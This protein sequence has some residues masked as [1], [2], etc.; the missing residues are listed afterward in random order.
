MIATVLLLQ[1][2]TVFASQI[3]PREI[4]N[5]L[6][7]TS[8]DG[9]IY[10]FDMSRQLSS[11]WPVDL[12]G[13]PV[14]NVIAC[15]L[16]DDINTQEF[17]L[18]VKKTDKYYLY[19]LSHDGKIIGNAGMELGFVPHSDP[20]IFK[21]GS[22]NVLFAGTKDG[23]VRAAAL[24]DMSTPEGWPI[25]IDKD[26]PISIAAADINND[27]MEEILASSGDK[28]WSISYKAS[29]EVS[30]IT[31]ADTKTAYSKLFKRSARTI[32]T[33]YGTDILKKDTANN[34][35]T[36]SGPF[37]HFSQ[38]EDAEFYLPPIYFSPNG[39]KDKADISIGLTFDKPTNYKYTLCDEN[40][41]TVADL[42]DGNGI[43]NGIEVF[44]W[45]G[46][47]K[48][49]PTYEVYDAVLTAESSLSDHINAKRKVILDT[50]PPSFESFTA[51]NTIFGANSSGNSGQQK[52][53]FKLSKKADLHIK[54]LDSNKNIYKEDILKNISAFPSQCILDGKRN[55]G[56]ASEESYGYL[57]CAEDF[58]GNLSA[59]LEGTVFLDPTPYIINVEPSPESV[60]TIVENP[61]PIVFKLQVCTPC[62]IEAQI[63][64]SSGPVKTIIPLSKYSSGEYKVSWEG[65]DDNGNKL[66]EGSYNYVFTAKYYSLSSEKNGTVRIDNSKPYASQISITPSEESV[67]ALD[68]M[69]DNIIFSYYLSEK[70][71]VTVDIL[72][73]S[74]DVV[75]SI[76]SSQP[77]EAK[78]NS[79]SF[80]KDKLMSGGVFEPGEYSIRLKLVDEAGNEETINKAKLTIISELSIS[81]AVALP[82]TFTPNG[83]NHDDY[84]TFRYKVSGGVGDV[85]A[86]VKI[87][88]LAGATMKTFTS[89][90]SSASFDLEIWDGKDENNNLCPDGQYQYEISASDNT[91]NQAS[92]VT[93]SLTLISD[94]TIV[95]YADPK[96]I[97]S[98]GNDMTIFYNINYQGQLITGNSQVSATIYDPSN[99]VVYNFSDTKGE[100]SYSQK[101]AGQNNQTGGVVPNGTY[102]LEAKS[103]DPTGTI[104]VY[105]TDIVVGAALQITGESASPAIFTPNGDD[106]DDTTTI[107][108]FV[109]C[110][111]GNGIST[112][113]IKSL[114]GTTV[115]VFS[116]PYSPGSNPSFTWDGKDG[117]N[118][119]CPDGKYTYVITAADPGSDLSPSVAGSIILA[120]NA[121][122]TIDADPKTLSP[123]SDGVDDSSTVH[124]AI[125]Y[126]GLFSGN[127]QISIGVLNQSGLKVYSLTDTKGEGSYS[128]VWGGENNQIGG[129]VPDG[130]YT[131]E[132][133]ATDPTGTVYSY[134]ADLIVNA[135]LQ[136]TGES[137]TPLIFTPNGD[138]HDD[139]TTLSYFVSGGVGSITSTVEIKSIAGTIVR[140]FTIP[141]ALSSTPYAPSFTWDGKDGSGSMCL[142]GEYTYKITVSDSAGNIYSSTPESIVLAANTAI[143]MY[144]TP[145]TLSPNG[146]GVTNASTMFCVISYGGLISG[147]SQVE[148][149]IFNPSGGK[150][151]SLT[152][153]KGEG[154]YSYVW[155]G[156]NNQTGG[157]VP[158]GTYTLK[159]QASDPTGANY[160]YTTD[161]SI[162]AE[163]KVTGESAVPVII[164]PNG[165][166]HNDNTTI[167]YFVSG[168]VGNGVS[169]V[170]IKSLASTTV[171]V[172]SSPYSPGS[173]PS[174]TWD[175]KDSSNNMCPDGKYIC[176]ISA[177]DSAGNTSSLTGGNITLVQS[178]TISLEAAPLKISPN[179]DGVDEYT[180]I[181]YAIDYKGGLI[182]GSSQIAVNI[183]DKSGTKVYSF[184]DSKGEGNYSLNWD[185][186]N[187]QTGGVV[188]DGTY[189]LEVQATDPTGTVY[190]FVADIIIDRGPPKI[191]DNGLSSAAPITP[192]GDSQQDD[193]TIKYQV[194]RVGNPIASIEV[195]IY[196]SAI[197]FDA[198]TLVR[199]ING[200]AGG[201]TLWDGRVD[202]PGGNG[203]KDGNGYADKGLYKYVIK[204]TD[205][206]GNTATLASNNTIEVDKVYL[207]FYP[208]ISI[209]NNPYFSPNGDGVKD[210][211][212]ITFQLMTTQ[213]SN[214]FY[215]KA[216]GMK[217]LSSYN[218]GKVTMKVK[219]MSGNTVKT[220]MNAVPCV[221]DL[222]Y[223]VTWDGTNAS[224]TIV[225]DGTY[226]FE[227]T[228]V[229]MIGDPAANNMIS[230]ITPN[231][232]DVV[233]DTVS[234]TV[235][236]KSP[237]N[238][239]WQKGNLDIFGTMTDQSPL[240]YSLGYGASVTNLC[241]GEGNISNGR[242]VS[243]DTTTVAGKTYQVNLYAVDRAGNT[244]EAQILC[245]IDND[246]PIVSTI[247]IESN[248]LPSNHYNPYTDGTV[249]VEFQ[250]DDNSF[251]TGKYTSPSTSVYMTTEVCYGTLQIKPLRTNNAVPSGLYSTGWNGINSSGD[252]VNDGNYQI[253]LTLTD[254]AGNQTVIT[255]QITLE[256]DQRMTSRESNTYSRYPNLMFNGSVLNLSYM[257]GESWGIGKFKNRTFNLSSGL[258][259]CRSEFNYCEW[260]RGEFEIAKQQNVTAESWIYSDSNTI[261]YHN[262]YDTSNVDHLNY[263][264]S[265]N[266]VNAGSY[267]VKNT[268]TSLSPGRYYVHARQYVADD[269]LG[270]HNIEI[271]YSEP[272]I[273]K[274]KTC[275]NTNNL[276][277]WN[278]SSLYESKTVESFASNS[279]GFITHYA[280]SSLFYFPQWNRTIFP[281]SNKEIIYSKKEGGIW[282]YRRT[283]SGAYDA[284]YSP[285]EIRISSAE[286]DS[287]NP[288]IAT[289][290]SGNKV[291]IAWEDWRHLKG[292]IYLRTSTTSGETWSAETQLI[293]SSENCTSP[294]LSFNGK[295]VYVAF[296]KDHG[297]HKELNIVRSEDG[298][299]SWTTPVRITCNHEKNG[300][301]FNPSIV[302]M[303]DGSAYIAWED[304]RTGTSEIY[305]QKIPYNFAPIRSAGFTALSMAAP[306]VM[307]GKPSF[308]IMSGNVTPE[309]ISP[310]DNAAVKTLRP[311]FKWYGVQNVTDYRIECATS[312]D[313]SSLANS[314]DYFTATISD[315]SGVKPVCEFTQNEHFMGLDEN[316]PS[317][318]FWYWRV[319]TIT[320]EASTSEVGSFRIELPASLSGVTNWPNP[321][322]PNK[323]RTKIRYRLG[324][325]PNSVTIRIYDITGALVKELDGTTNP[326]GASIWNKYNDVEWDGR[327]GRGDMVLNG[328]YPFEISVNY[329]DKSVTGRGKAVVL[330]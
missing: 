301:A 312:S 176:E 236:I 181:S 145:K 252:Y 23:Y 131:L 325:E 156:Q 134:T 310:I 228:A 278:T 273:N 98:S 15:E 4:N 64:G 178:P 6:F 122:I 127:S 172:F 141:Y 225:P 177:F 175:G 192:N 302:A 190:P 315:V 257:T 233:V 329:G 137:A 32:K 30:E 219:D 306:V 284:E 323:E 163:L 215:T 11:G 171:K 93:G 108:Y 240:N 27:N 25:L 316:T 36:E 224:G 237:A 143:S 39:N 5:Q 21:T 324:R 200:S 153:T 196:D 147:D 198:S 111:V 239:S 81:N 297:G 139:N 193:V 167:S 91:G 31:N 308:T 199:H 186:L 59:T 303:P 113:E 69:T 209:P 319:Q 281:N 280:W 33:Y 173:N 43:P 34:L 121:S 205:V 102:R 157:F 37:H 128:Y 109:S 160:S 123:N 100:G 78:G 182:S 289:D 295:Y 214:P 75:S 221:K 82:L 8:I 164:T 155:G 54:Y 170:E 259:S 271:S 197:T 231:F 88:S 99:T 70:C 107:S 212:T 97:S 234:P 318:P 253:I 291:F 57:I 206:V 142:D 136:I 283:N 118:N 286:G 322:D 256:D 194:T 162:S 311:T 130:T 18:F 187:N 290:T 208:P 261:T 138:N 62:D 77:Q 63:I 204:A 217:I 207:S 86:K 19:T 227:V 60:S 213:E 13:M 321:F 125:N 299:T 298:G 158:D 55:N 277:G 79:V 226:T 258:Q 246:P 151:Y 1:T 51:A 210:T 218:V 282:K 48:R 169:T 264:P 41:N 3:A 148:M 279:S 161:L 80:S 76:I 307:E 179:G 9:R 67:Q 154:N 103:S 251:N 266:S 74:G 26:K 275:L 293:S 188:L 260:F 90:L 184:S 232:S 270:H 14:S 96:A 133:Q 120:A 45:D 195:G 146:D 85:T 185:G 287:I 49:S 105:A 124:Y 305:F 288:A 44:S 174:F 65:S 129:F 115:K 241:S 250:V 12:D 10:K 242:L 230:G 243:W 106:H 152:D 168:G 244:S 269:N 16:D 191:T 112:V 330:K 40:G 104:Y 114:A 72:N 183:Y 220:L 203:D 254:V 272:K 28:L 73:A 159:M 328:V 314:M 296:S 235:E 249:S 2:G 211:T 101:W 52:I 20:V 116:S 313:E 268:M 263:T 61:K 92:T 216:K 304:T 66:A 247:S 58:A 317:H 87:K 46:G 150:V 94:P 117:S 42:K 95:V 38:P 7:T 222:T 119:M 110:G 140:S 126:G 22:G 68:Q 265:H 165:D 238:N 201:D 17:A 245:N 285:V 29:W 202:V 267:D 294:T 262:V 47:G 180:T 255:N 71:Y 50:I 53:S 229:D 144:A 248:G 89:I 326:E 276:T 84:V 83:D 292:E 24:K 149:D 135:G 56:A 309:L 327:N 320:S 189:T 274:M 300:N 132:V 35:V 223:S 166:N